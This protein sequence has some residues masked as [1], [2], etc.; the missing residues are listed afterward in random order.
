M[1]DKKPPLI[2][3]ISGLMLAATAGRGLLQAFEI[4]DNYRWLMAGLLAL[5]GLL[6]FSELA[7]YRRFH[8]YLKIYFVIQASIVVV[9]LLLPLPPLE[10]PPTTDFYA[11]LFIPLCAQAIVYFKRPASYY[12]FAALTAASV[13]AL[14]FQ[15]S[16][17]DAVKFSVTY[18]LAYA[19]VGLLAY[20][21]VNAEEAK[22]ELNLA[23][24]KLQ[25]YAGQVE[26]LAVAEERNR[27]AR[28]LHDSVTQSLYSLTLFAA[29]ASEELSAGNIDIVS[30]HLE[31]LRQTSQQALQEMRLMVFELRPPELEIKGL[32]LALKERLEAVESRSGVE[33]VINIGF[34]GRLPSKMERGLYSIAREAMNNILKHSQATKTTINLKKEG[35]KVIFEIWDNGIGFDHSSYNFNAGL[36][37][38]GM[39]ERADR[40]GA[41]LSLEA[42]PEGGTRLRVEVPDDGND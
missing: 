12:W 25:E 22:N 24:K 19:L 39:Q 10:T 14:F 16:L 21:Y 7:I 9:L 2:Y 15:Y 40:I 26:A 27:L 42:N 35:G 36:G 17:I 30:E 37:I 29:A 11:L 8:H 6:L 34:E 1:T 4:N 23:N 32:A 5:F 41:N 38:K 28:D 31:D 20:F 13:A 18:I 33:T 3:A